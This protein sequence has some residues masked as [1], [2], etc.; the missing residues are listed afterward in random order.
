VF[1]RLLFR[2]LYDKGELNQV[3]FTIGLVFAASAIAAYAAA[4]V[5]YSAS[6]PEALRG[7]VEIGGMRLPSYRIFLVVVA[8]ILSGLVVWGLDYTRAGSLIRACVDNQKVARG[9]GINVGLVF[10]LTFAL[11]SGLA[12]LGGALAVDPRAAASVMRR[13]GVRGVDEDVGIHHEHHRPSIAW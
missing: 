5:H 4:T 12:G 2:R 3:L 13:I 7:F 1:E 8:V 10:A 9:L 6:L 11:G